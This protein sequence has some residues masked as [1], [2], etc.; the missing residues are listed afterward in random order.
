MK[1]MPRDRD[2]GQHSTPLESTMRVAPRVG[3]VKYAHGGIC[4]S[5]LPLYICGVILLLRHVER[6]NRLDLAERQHEGLSASAR[7]VFSYTNV[8]AI[9]GQSK[10]T[11]MLMRGILRG[12]IRFF[13]A[14]PDAFDI[15][16]QAAPPRRDY[17]MMNP[18]TIADV[19]DTV[20]RRI[21]RAK[22]VLIL[23]SLNDGTIHASLSG[24]SD[25]QR[26][27]YPGTD[28]GTTENTRA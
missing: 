16:S 10:D 17:I 6:R 28:A 12:L 7:V 20:N 8:F 22:R 18:V 4:T 14:I 19:V 25:A 24:T 11:V 27:S 3:T 9:S 26:R 13:R 23:E 2:C 1:E 15:R 21:Y 5:A